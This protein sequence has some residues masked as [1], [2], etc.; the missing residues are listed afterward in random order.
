METSDMSEA[1]EAVDRLMTDIA[2]LKN[3]EHFRRFH[4]AVPIFADVSGQHL[5]LD[6]KPRDVKLPIDV[7]TVNT[8][9][10]GKSHHRWMRLRMASGVA[11]T[12]LARDY[13][14]KKRPIMWRFDE[15][16]RLLRDDRLATGTSWG[17]CSDSG[18]W[19][20]LGWG[21]HVC[22]VEYA[23][24]FE[25][26][27]HLRAHQSAEL[28]GRPILLAPNVVY[29]AASMLAGAFNARY[30][31]S[32]IIAEDNRPGIAFETDPAGIRELFRDRDLPAG[33]TR[34]AALLHWVSK[35]M[36][37]SRSDP[38]ALHEVRAYLR[39]RRC[40][41]WHGYRCEIVPSAY[42]LERLPP[43]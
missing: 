12:R 35:H 41:S 43:N 15:A 40:F 4:G 31:W 25:A 34:R 2:A 42:D 37:K 13:H 8:F 36:R 22:R 20:F 6:V 18:Q 27:E 32:A 14:G 16:G 24:H 11:A 38:D 5:F 9:G 19:S 26:R 17:A 10:A 23:S 1:V 33:H 28:E 21:E 39:G 29:M 30:L 3:P 7:R